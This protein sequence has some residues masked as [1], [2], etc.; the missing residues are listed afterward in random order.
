M[1]IFPIKIVS[2]QPKSC[3]ISIIGMIDHSDNYLLCCHKMFKQQ[4][5]C[6]LHWLKLAK[7]IHRILQSIHSYFFY[8]VFL[9]SFFF[10]YKYL[11]CR[12]VAVIL[13][14]IYSGL[15]Y[16]LYVPDWQF[17]VSVST[18]SLPPIDGGYIYTVR[19]GSAPLSPHFAIFSVLQFLFWIW[20]AA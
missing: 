12:F 17:D 19:V 16:G 11:L 14:A 3:Y 10:F 20:P 18:S 1:Y 13:L 4:D 8:I 2:S 5:Y 9:S 6:I 15:L 7:Y